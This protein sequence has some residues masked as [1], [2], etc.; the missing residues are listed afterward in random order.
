MWST[1]GVE[2]CLLTKELGEWDGGGEGKRKKTG[3][4]KRKGKKRPQRVGGVTNKIVISVIK[5]KRKGDKEQGNLGGLSDKTL[6]GCWKIGS[7][8]KGR[9]DLHDK[10]TGTKKKGIY[11]HVVTGG[12]TFKGRFAWEQTGKSFWDLQTRGK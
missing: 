7:G 12:K 1:K 2:G 5:K 9:K 6:E 11:Q 4:S 8:K 10:K 3:D